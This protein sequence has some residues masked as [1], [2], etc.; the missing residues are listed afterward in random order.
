MVRA[1]MLGAAFRG[2]FDKLSPAPTALCKIM[3]EAGKAFK[4]NF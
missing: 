4:T 1:T 3:W 2:E